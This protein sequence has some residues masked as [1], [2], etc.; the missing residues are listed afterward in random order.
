MKPY[1]CAKSNQSRA[2]D[3]DEVQP[4]TEK[5]N[6]PIV[7]GCWTTCCEAV[8]PPTKRTGTWNRDWAWRKYYDQ[9]KS[10]KRLLLSI[11]C[12]FS[13][14][15]HKHFF[16]TLN[17]LFILTLSYF[18]FWLGFW[19]CLSPSGGF[20]DGG[21]NVEKNTIFTRKNCVY[22]IKNTNWEKW[23]VVCQN[24]LFKWATLTNLWISLTLLNQTEKKELN[25]SRGD[26]A[27]AM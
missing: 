9:W 6:G 19:P 2:N 14:L 15:A 11:S 10:G 5:R 4:P 12:H 8:R 18:F 26:D 27:V 17:R 16:F 13:L 24:V 20:H 21:E 25:Y 7:N 23:G 3:D 22:P 1:E